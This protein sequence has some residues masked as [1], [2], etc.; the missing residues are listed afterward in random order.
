MELQ[1]YRKQHVIDLLN[2]QGYSQLAEEAQRV[3]PD[4]VDVDRLAEWAIKH[5]LT[6]DGLIS[7]MGGSP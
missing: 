7:R 4:P 6:R 3:L 5:G 1:E 2:R